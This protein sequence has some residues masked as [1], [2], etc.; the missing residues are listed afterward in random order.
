MMEV[1]SVAW[2]V[3]CR[4]AKR[5]KNG[6]E[7]TGGSWSGVQRG[8]GGRFFGSAHALSRRV[9][10]AGM[11]MRLRGGNGRALPRAL[12][13]RPTLSSS[14]AFGSRVV[15]SKHHMFGLVRMRVEKAI[16]LFETRCLLHTLEEPGLLASLSPRIS[17]ILT[18]PSSAG[19]PARH[20]MLTRNVALLSA[21][22]SR[23]ILESDLA[24]QS[25]VQYSIV[26]P[27]TQHSHIHCIAWCPLEKANKDL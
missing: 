4:R 27:S 3:E 17:L 9:V 2:V 23:T 6:E 20:R 7:S 16:L 11:F 1:E 24:A 21:V 19:Q 18:L 25:A 5:N 14:P 26:H 13:D 10:G 8:C 22:I 15:P 12:Q